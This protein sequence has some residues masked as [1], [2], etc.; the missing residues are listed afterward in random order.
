MCPEEAISGDKKEQHLINASFCIECG[1]C[2]RICPESA[3]RDDK[4]A[5]VA[6]MKKA[7]WPKPVIDTKHCSACENCV[8]VCPGGARPARQM[9]LLRLVQR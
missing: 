8:A 3:V 1:S 2:G 5:V 9:R 7:Y 6:K 4:G